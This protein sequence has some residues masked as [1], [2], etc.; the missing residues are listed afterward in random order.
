M[1]AAAARSYF[2]Q[3]MAARDKLL[4]AICEL[5]LMPHCEEAASD[6]ARQLD[7]Y[8]MQLNRLER[9][10]KQATIGWERAF[11]ELGAAHLAADRKS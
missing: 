11:A 7:Y 4:N 1:R 10:E 6:M 2:E 9:Y 5:S 8:S 3:V